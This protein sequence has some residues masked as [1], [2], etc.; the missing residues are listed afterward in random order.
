MT[1]TK[2]DN[3]MHYCT[4]KVNSNAETAQWSLT[5]YNIAGEMINYPNMQV[6]INASVRNETR[7]WETLANTDYTVSCPKVD[8][9]IKS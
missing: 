3:I 8:Y 5:R 7:M 6:K 1:K 9:C 4:R 2:K